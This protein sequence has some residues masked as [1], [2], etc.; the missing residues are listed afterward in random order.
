[1]TQEYSVD[2]PEP[3]FSRWMRDLLNDQ[4]EPRLGSTDSDRRRVS[5]IQTSPPKTTS[6]SGTNCAKA[7]ATVTSSLCLRHARP[8]RSYEQRQWL[9]P[10]R[11]PLRPREMTSAVGNLTSAGRMSMTSP[12]K[13][14][15]ENSQRICHKATI[16]VDRIGDPKR[17]PVLTG[18]I[19][20]A[21][22]FE[23]VP[24]ANQARGLE[25]P[26]INGLTPGGI[27]IGEGCQM[28]LFMNSGRSETRSC[29]DPNRA[30]RVVRSKL[31]AVPPAPGPTVAG[32]LLLDPCGICAFDVSDVGNLGGSRLAEVLDG[33][34]RK[35][36]LVA[37]SCL[38]RLF[39]GERSERCRHKTHH[40][41]AGRSC[42]E[43][44]VVPWRGLAIGGGVAQSDLVSFTTPPTT[45][46]FE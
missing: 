32:R 24:K 15:Y 11:T 19:G 40:F 38:L 23:S 26:R 35:L 10:R 21:G 31:S 6:N 8:I 25:C 20:T 14:N 36:G 37:V 7:I 4:S 16:H 33:M 42:L 5:Y 27:D 45:N 41:L 3:L 29:S 30:Y 43:S 9:A 12:A 28:C 2:R 46:G 1:M 17:I 39:Y 44:D 22:S 34:V 18:K 13:S